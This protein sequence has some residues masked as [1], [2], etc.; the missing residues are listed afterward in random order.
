M[1][2]LLSAAL[3][4]PELRRLA[5]KY[6]LLFALVAGGC[7][8]V[9]VSVW[10]LVLMMMAPDLKPPF[11]TSNALATLAMAGLPL[12]GFLFARRRYPVTPSLLPA[13]LVFAAVAAVYVSISIGQAYAG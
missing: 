12:A 7:G 13:A 11:Q 6:G 8:T 2:T 9:L 10:L 5:A 1:T 4:T 3:M